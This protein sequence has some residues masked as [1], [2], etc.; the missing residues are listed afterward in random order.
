MNNRDG[1]SPWPSDGETEYTPFD[2]GIVRYED[3]KG[4]LRIF[5]ANQGYRSPKL[6]P[7]SKEYDKAKLDPKS[8]KYDRELAKQ[9]QMVVKM[10]VASIY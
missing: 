8:D 7:K 2:Y 5:H 1:K 6:D 9:K 3:A 4:L 10:I